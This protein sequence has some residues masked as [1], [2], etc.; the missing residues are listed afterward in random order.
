MADGALQNYLKGM[1]A[2]LHELLPTS[3][4]PKGN[5][6]LTT[7]ATTDGKETTAASK[8]DKMDVDDEDAVAEEEEE[9][10]DDEPRKTRGST[11]KRGAAP[12][13]P[14]KRGRGA[15]AAATRATSRS[16]S[17]TRKGRSA[18]KRGTRAQ[19]QEEDEDAKQESK[20]DE[21]SKAEEEQHATAN[22]RAAE[23]EQQRDSKGEQTP[24]ERLPK[25]VRDVETIVA[26]APH[27]VLGARAHLAAIERLAALSPLSDDE[28]DD[29][30]SDA[31]VAR[32][33]EDKKRKADG[34]AE[35]ADAD[36]EH[37]DAEGTVGAE[38]RKKKKQ[39]RTGSGGASPP[40]STSPA[41]RAGKMPSRR[42]TLSSKS[43]QSSTGGSTTPAGGRESYVI[44]PT[45][46]AGISH[47]PVPGMPTPSL[48]TPS[49]IARRGPP[50]RS[51]SYFP[52]QRYQAVQPQQHAATDPGSVSKSEGGSQ[53]STQLFPELALTSEPG[54]NPHV[55]RGVSGASTPVAP[56]PGQQQ[57]QATAAKGKQ[58]AQ[59]TPGSP[60]FT[61][62]DGEADGTTSADDDADMLGGAATRQVSAPGSGPP[63]LAVSDADANKSA[64]SHE[65]LF[66][67]VNSVRL[68]GDVL[69]R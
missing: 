54:N 33:G 27:S 7:T 38:S 39:R 16:P 15:D 58:R 53:L 56:T 35:V 47:T 37:S 69:D 49:G 29:D 24:R 67:V 68:F 31:D 11:R 14:P 1:L 41:R 2:S 61:S 25:S 36:D 23:R 18:A 6:D 20:P 42:P 9:E 19:A 62:T 52:P 4:D 32:D 22:A 12:A 60:N 30:E 43:R 66:E 57:Q 45:V 21:G 65:R 3:S 55:T 51:S 26:L 8:E 17:T 46:I 50:S 59:L 63:A 48:G 40:A 64:D 5:E 28:S 44:D 13:S 34:T 10:E